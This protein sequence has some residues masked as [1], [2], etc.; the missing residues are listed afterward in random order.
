MK[1]VGRLSE[2]AQEIASLNDGI[3]D[4]TRS[5]SDR[6]MQLDDLVKNVS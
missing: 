5:I 2:M 3:F 1:T 4:L 6:A